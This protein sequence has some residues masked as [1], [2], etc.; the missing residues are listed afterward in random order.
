M[1]DG[2]WIIQIQTPQTTTGGVMILSKGKIFG[3]DNGFTWIGTYSG[4]QRLMKGRVV[5]HN[6]DPAVPSVL[7]ASGDYEMHF[8]GNVEGTAITG[9]AMIAGQAQ[10]SVG[11]R[12]IKRADL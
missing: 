11:V 3:G 6:F 8:S 10:H 9:T 1:L 4:D 7:G 2:F 12:M 5:V